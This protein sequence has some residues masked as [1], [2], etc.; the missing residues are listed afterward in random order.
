MNITDMTAKSNIPVI[1]VTVPKI[2][3]ANVGLESELKF[4]SFVR[5][6]R[7]SNGWVET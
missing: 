7:C 4:I 6:L 5:H 2:Q 1:P 3:N